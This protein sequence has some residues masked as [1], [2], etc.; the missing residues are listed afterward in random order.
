[1]YYPLPGELADG[2]LR[3]FHPQNYPFTTMGRIPYQ[4]NCTINTLKLIQPPLHFPC[5]SHT[6]S[7]I[8]HT[9]SLYTGGR[10]V[11]VGNVSLFRNG[12][13][14]SDK[15]PTDTPLVV[16]SNNPSR[17]FY[18]LQIVFNDYEA[19]NWSWATRAVVYR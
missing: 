11:N 17:H 6:V 2:K 15:M 12:T 1:M 16:Y 9:I 7:D 18:E 3:K 14:L 5:N 19:K 10:Y 8:L 13:L 4:S